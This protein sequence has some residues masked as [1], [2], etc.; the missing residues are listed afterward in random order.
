MDRRES[1]GQF[2]SQRDAALDGQRADFA[3]EGEQR[4][5]ID[6]RILPSHV[7]LP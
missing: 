7:R 4:G 2:A 5:T 6:T 3:H 1:L